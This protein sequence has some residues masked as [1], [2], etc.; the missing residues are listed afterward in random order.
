[1]CKRTRNFSIAR[2]K[3]RECDYFYRLGAVIV[4]G[5]KILAIASNTRKGHAEVNAI[6]QASKTEGADIYVTR[7]T[8]TGM[9]MAKPCD[10]CM[11]AIK[12]AGIRRIYYTSRDGYHKVMV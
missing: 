12:A 4:K 3:A 5:G 6:K 11:E 7:H 8:P 9:A 10:N 1:M 2:K